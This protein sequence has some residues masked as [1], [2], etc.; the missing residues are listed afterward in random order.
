MIFALYY[1]RKMNVRSIIADLNRYTE[2]EL[3]YKRC[4][5]LR[6][7]KKALKKY[8]ASFDPQYLEERRLILPN[9]SWYSKL[10][11]EFL[12][13]GHCE[14]N[15]YLT[16]HY[17]YTPVFE[18]CHDYFETF[19]VLSG[20]CENVIGGERFILPAGSLCF[21]APQVNHS[22]GV[23]SDCVVINIFIRKTTFDDIFFPLLK[24]NDILSDFFMGNIYAVKPIEYIIFNMGDDKEMT[25]KVF[26]LLSEQYRNDK[27]SS[28]IMEYLISIFFT[29]LIRKHEN[30]PIIQ[31]T[32]NDKHMQRYIAY[33]NEN[34]RTVTLAQ[35]ARHF[36]ISTAH[37]SRLIKAQTGK[38]FT[39]LVRDI[40]LRHAQSL[41]KSSNMKIYDISYSLGYE[42]QETFIRSF[43]NAF[44]VTPG[45]YR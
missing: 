20:Q 18:H 5:E 26:D 42:N 3:F 1:N 22:L 31:R 8:I 2:D 24:T 30:K 44:G 21:I 27:Y 14:Q 38:H 40:R 23:F 37:C 12:F 45:Q 33:I 34:F 6:S 29:F 11:E 35:V 10:A 19:F 32:D 36:S 15:V 43:K 17:R 16:K 25:G 7:D 13:R 28:R 41:L 4:Y 39:D 9:V